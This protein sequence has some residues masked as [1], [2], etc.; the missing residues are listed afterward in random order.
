MRATLRVCASVFGLLLAM[1]AASLGDEA[2][3]ADSASEW[4]P[5]TSSAGC[6]KVCRKGK[7]CGNSCIARDKQCH[8]PPG[9]ACDA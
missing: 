2:A 3:A 4:Q 1:T 8:Q 9:C 6:C 7:A 5:V